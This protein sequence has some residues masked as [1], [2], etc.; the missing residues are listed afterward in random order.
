M[1]TKLLSV[2]VV[3]VFAVA[4]CKKNEGDK[5]KPEPKP[6]AG[7]TTEKTPE[8]TP[9]VK[10][11]TGEDTMKKL[12]ETTAAWN[13]GDWDKFAGFYAENAKMLMVDHQPPMSF[14][15]RKAMLDGL[16]E[17]MP[18]FSDNKVMPQLVLVN[19]QNYAT[20]VLG[21]STNSGDFMG[22]PATNAKLSHYGSGIG[23]L[24]DKGMIVEERHLSDQST[25]MH[26]MGMK[27]PM[28]P[29]SETEWPEAIKVVATNSETETK[30]AE[31]ARKS[32]AAFNAKDMKAIGEMMADDVSFRY[33]P[34]KETVTGK[35]AYL[36]GLGEWYGMHET[37]SMT[38]K[39]AWGAGDW[40]VS[41]V[42]TK[43]KLGA[44]I[45]NFKGTKGKE[46]TSTHFHFTHV[47]DGKVKAQWIFD[48]SLS[49]MVQVG[50]VDMSKM[51]PGAK[52]KDAPA[53]AP[54]K[55]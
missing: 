55:K 48:N 53:K 31:M 32:D 23:R 37:I 10:K 38:T 22:M 54:A 16:K 24:D 7:K 42:E 21:T 18:A 43:G 25:F 28:S 36:K 4:S 51:G 9:E 40:V 11:W 49:M 1:K 2:L 19:G 3:A 35:E 14:D 20:I 29:D 17:M 41:V 50:A 5:K 47:K 15:S 45:P 33:V 46:Y 30:N 8:K 39:E 44:D 26:Q 27:N 34:R 52:G 6:T 13:A 12:D